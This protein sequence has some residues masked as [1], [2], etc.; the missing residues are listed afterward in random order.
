VPRTTPVLASSASC[1]ER[2]SSTRQLAFT[3]SSM[4]I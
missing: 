3:V 1:V 4:S 2:A